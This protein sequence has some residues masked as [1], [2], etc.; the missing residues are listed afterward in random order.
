MPNRSLSEIDYSRLQKQLQGRVYG[1]D[2]MRWLYSTDASIYRIQPAGVVIPKGAE[3]LDATLAFAR[4]EGLA[5]TARG[6]GTSLGGQALGA[7]LQL[8][9]FPHFKGI[10]EINPEAGWARVQPGVVLDHLNAALAPHG[11][12][13]GPDVATSARAT[14]GGMISNNS[15][16]ARSIVYGKT[17]DHVLEL[18]VLLSDGTR[19]TL[20]SLDAQAWAVKS[21]L[22]SLEGRIYASLD[23]EITAHRAEIEKR[24]PKILRRV[25]GYNLDAFLGTGDKNLSWLVTGSEGTLAIIRE[26]K[27]RLSPKPKYRGLLII[28]C[29][30]LADALEANHMILETRPSAAEVMDQMLLDLTR[31]NPLYAR[32][33]YFLEQPTEVLLMV[34]YMADSET[35]LKS[36]LATGEQFARAHGLGTG[37]TALTDEQVQA[38]VWAIRKAG[39]PLLYSR[40]GDYKPVTFV[41]DTAVDPAQLRDFIAEFD[42]LVKAHDTVAAYYAHAS[43]GCIHIRPMMDLKQVSEVRKMRSLAEAVLELVLRYGGAMSGEH[44]DGIARSEF[45]ERLFGREVY[46]VFRRLKASWDP[47]RQLNPGNIT[48][49]PP[50]DSHLRY[51]EGYRPLPFETELKYTRQE[52]YQALVELCNG[53]GGCRKIGSGT[54]CPPF[55]A[56]RN[57]EDSTRARANLLRRLLVEPDLLQ[58]ASERQTLLD[59]LDLCVGCKACKTEC[60][61]KVDMAKLKAETLHQ[62]H[63]L[64]GVP[65]R[66]RLL[67]NVKWLN[68]A[69]SLAAPMSNLLLKL[70]PV[71]QLMEKRLGIAAHRPLPPFAAVPFDY[72]FAH[73]PA[74]AENRPA[75]VLFNDCYMN[76]NHPEVGEAT[77]KVLEAFG[78]RVIVPE[79]VCCG[80]PQ[81]SFGLLD[82]AR[83]STRRVLEVYQPYLRQGLQV[84][85]CEPS[86]VLSFRD[87][88]LDFEPE[89]AQALAQQSLTLQ[90]W[91]VAEAVRRPELPF[92]PHFQDQVF[93]HEHCH[94]KSLVGQ[95]VAL[96]ALKLLPNLDVVMSPAGCCGMAG[97][98]GYEAEHVEMSRAIASERLLPALAKYPSARVGVSGISCR[99]Q[100]EAE[101]GREVRHLAEILAAALLSP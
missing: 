59:V 36:K 29:Q 22:N 6:G 82:E 95:E 64:H 96:A 66:S 54:M 19:T 94:Q 26:A 2:S 92:T 85:G 27:I 9:F 18:E 79:Q 49:A 67:G 51:G 11:Y 7:G 12:W 13:F 91:L 52:S 88:Y 57:E 34:E 35:E 98:F 20:K 72:R 84:V 99:H 3:D 1:D 62:D 56:T 40:P 87:E 76:Y 55:M 41:E 30:N 25:S 46:Q 93:F 86:C 31:Q 75:I 24:F 45:N 39:L 43:A 97:A 73:R 44:G 21:R 47:H 17:I 89:A 58:I 63:Q 42:E 32:K 71:R 37:C 77:V 10:L 16:G 4:S 90:E 28:Y 50:M 38:D 60:P 14:L 100:I 80:R 69:G 23:A 5:I 83:A 74:P 8:D 15:A 101:T 68:H 48:D 53:C 78:Y 81:L 70:P 33:L 65:L 61:S